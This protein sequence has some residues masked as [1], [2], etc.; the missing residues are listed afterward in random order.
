MTRV[1]NTLIDAV[2]IVVVFVAY[3]LLFPVHW[4]VARL[5]K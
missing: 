4:L 2:A 3:V 1:V 5:W